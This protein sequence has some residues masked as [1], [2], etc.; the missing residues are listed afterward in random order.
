MVQINLGDIGFDV[1]RCTNCK[2]NQVYDKELCMTCLT[3][4]PKKRKNIKIIRSNR[5]FKRSNN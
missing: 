4:Q 3:V 2:I 5:S 1:I